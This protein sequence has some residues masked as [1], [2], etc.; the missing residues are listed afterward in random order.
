MVTY[1][2]GVQNWDWKSL[3]SK[4]KENVCGRSQKGLTK[5]KNRYNDAKYT[6]TIKKR[7]VWT[8][9][10]GPSLIFVFWNHRDVFLFSLSSLHF[11]I[12]LHGSFY[13]PRHPVFFQIKRDLSVKTSARFHVTEAAFCSTTTA[14]LSQVEQFQC[15]WLTHSRVT[16]L[17]TNKKERHA[18]VLLM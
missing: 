7:W 14:A 3:Y 8:R 17:Q 15:G 18:V 5:K 9:Q 4:N 13:P 2:Q 16:P 12:L 6:A 1:V 11:I 10:T